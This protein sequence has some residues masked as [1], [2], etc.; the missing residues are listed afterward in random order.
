MVRKCLDVLN[1]CVKVAVFAVTRDD[2]EGYSRTLGGSHCPDALE[3][4]GCYT[5]WRHSAFHSVA[6]IAHLLEGDGRHASFPI[7]RIGGTL[8]LG[9][10]NVP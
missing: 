5:L 1:L 8:S 2:F 6:L 7:L 4:W 10:L 3:T 9:R